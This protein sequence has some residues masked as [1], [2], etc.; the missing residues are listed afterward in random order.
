MLAF[1][2][3]I[4]QRNLKISFDLKLLN[5]YTRYFKFIYLTKQT[6]KSKN[7]SSYFAY[8]IY[9]TAN[10]NMIKTLHRKDI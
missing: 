4:R 1:Y 3:N 10:K 9:L 2:I 5:I 6:F 8:K 7:K